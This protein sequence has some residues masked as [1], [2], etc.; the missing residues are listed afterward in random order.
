MPL[1]DEDLLDLIGKE[2]GV[3]VELGRLISVKSA[4]N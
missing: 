2:V 3:F 4:L 1:S